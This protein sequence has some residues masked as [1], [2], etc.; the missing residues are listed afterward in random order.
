[1]P[2][3]IP[4]PFIDQVLNQTD[5]VDLINGYI[6]LKQKGKEYSA[7]CPFHGEKT[8]S[9]TVSPEK[10]FYHCFGCGAHGTAINFLMEHEGL[11]FI[12][13]IEVLATRLGLEVVTE[14]GG[15]YQ[16]DNQQLYQALE[17]ANKYYQQQLRSNE[18]A[19]SYLKSRGI[20]GEV[21]ANFD[22]GYAPNGFN[23]IS[24]L[25]SENFEQPTL[26]KAG[27]LKENSDKKIYDRFRHRIMFPIKD[28]RGR[29]IG[30]GGRVIDDDMPKYLNSPETELFHKSNTIYGIHEA[31][32]AL[33]KIK[34]LIIVEGYMDVVALNQHDVVN[35]V[36]TLGTA[37]TSQNIKNLLRYCS[38]LVFCFDGDRAGNDAAWKALQNILPEFKDGIN[39]RFAFMPQGEDPD[40]YIRSIGKDAFCKFISNAST[41]SEYFFA[42]LARDI[43][44]S[45]PDGKA[46][47]ASNAKPLLSKLP[48]TVFKDLMFKELNQRVGTVIA[49]SSL[50]S[51]SQDQNN[52]TNNLKQARAL[53]YTKTRL[54][55]ALLIRDP[56][57]AQHALSFE[58]LT[59]LHSVAGIDLFI[60]LLEIIEAE[61]NISAIALVERFHDKESYSALK[62]LL[63]WDP[64]DMDNRE[65]SFIK[66]MERFKE[67]IRKHELDALI[68]QEN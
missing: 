39:I 63:T 52:R 44:V 3:K 19:I 23:N 21:A 42:K 2:G 7:C 68:Q 45:T 9:F 30:F 60:E 37:T 6:D 25:L 32:N 50:A 58:E 22:I 34:Q 49:G 5:I 43:D 14:Q 40:S 51:D 28:P 46:K 56:A 18:I 67:D 10:Q 65:L 57:L 55:I 54:A 4:Q 64:P 48:A 41:L 12:E 8:P 11:Q 61:P 26:I 27:L 13:A 20:S 17:L 31:R 62:K 16:N 24:T 33:G 38:D 53:K 59:H 15:T 66:T 29:V 1:M 36:A 35:S 47:L